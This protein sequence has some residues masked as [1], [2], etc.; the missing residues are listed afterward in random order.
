M[1]ILCNEVKNLLKIGYK[2]IIFPEG[3]RQEEKTIGKFKPGIFAIQKDIIN[4]VYP[5][6]IDSGRAWSKSGKIKRNN[7]KVKV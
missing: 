6:F 1:K 4:M 3:T 7:I 5:I 2:V